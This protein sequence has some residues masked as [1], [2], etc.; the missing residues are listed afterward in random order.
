MDLSDKCKKKLDFLAKELEMSQSDIVRQAINLL[1]LI[2]RETKKGHR[3]KINETE[4]ILPWV[5]N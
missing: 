5:E 3:I 2:R 4:I 1:F